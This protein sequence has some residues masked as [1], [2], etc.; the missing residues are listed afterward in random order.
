MSACASPLAS[1]SIASWRWCAVSHILGL[2]TR[3]AAACTEDQL[4]L[5]LRKAA[6][7]REHQPTMRWSLYPPND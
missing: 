5:E 6:A 7:H 4:A 3:P 1:R 2:R